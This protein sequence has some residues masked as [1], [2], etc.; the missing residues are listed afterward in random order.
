LKPTHEYNLRREL[1][2]V[3]RFGN[4]ANPLNHAHILCLPLHGETLAAIISAECQ[5]AC[6]IA[7][8]TKLLDKRSHRIGAI[9]LKYG[10]DGKE[11]EE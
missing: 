11:K 3:F 9:I 7:T 1:L 10:M 2:L 5:I 6:T 8:T 4:G